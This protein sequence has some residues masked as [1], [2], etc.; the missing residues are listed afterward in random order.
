MSDFYTEE[1]R[2]NLDHPEVLEQ[3]RIWYCTGYCGVLAVTIRNWLGW[4][5]YGVFMDD[6]AIPVHVMA[7]D[8]LG[9]YWDAYGQQTEADLIHRYKPV[10]KHAHVRPWMKSCDPFV[11]DPQDY[12]FCREIDLDRMI[13]EIQLML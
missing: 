11:R 4:P 6:S 5:I 7:R 1:S 10:F 12:Q 8:P 9:G 3:L 2:E 13:P